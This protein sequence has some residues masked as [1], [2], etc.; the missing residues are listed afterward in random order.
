MAVAEAIGEA[1]RMIDT[2]A[3]VG[4]NR[5]HVTKTGINGDVQWGKS[6]SPEELRKVLPAMVR[7]AGKQEECDLLDKSGNVT[8]KARAGGNLMVRP[9]SETSAFIQLDDLT[10]AKLDRVRPASFLT[11]RTS[12]GNHQAWMHGLP[13]RASPMTRTARTSPAGL[14]NRYQRIPRPPAPS[15][16]P[17]R[18]TS[19]PNTSGIFRRWRLLMP[20][21]AALRHKKRSKPLAWLP[22][23]IPPT[24]VRLKTFRSDSRLGSDKSWPDYASRPP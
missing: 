6:Y 16:S 18:P 24:V 3:S 20:S 9:M 4:A 2:F 7:V 17:A 22:L 23:Q 12:P 19:K 1:L 15:A 8:G 10:E 11:V 21:L 13:S 5:V 14:R